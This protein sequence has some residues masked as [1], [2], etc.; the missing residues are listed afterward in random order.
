MWLVRE[1]LRL[2][3]RV[4]LAQPDRNWNEPDRNE[5]QRANSRHQKWPRRIAP[6]TTRHPM[7]NRQTETPD[8]N[9]PP[10]QVADEI[11]PKELLSVIYGTKC[12][13][14]CSHNSDCQ[15]QL[16]VSSKRQRFQ[17]VVSH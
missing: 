12:A 10:K 8:G 17:L 15:R 1:E 11:G 13:Q 6:V 4:N 5:R 3:P 9:H 2:H 7:K 16:L 14:A